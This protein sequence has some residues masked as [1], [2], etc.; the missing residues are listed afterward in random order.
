[1]SPMKHAVLLLAFCLSGVCACGGSGRDE[2]S[3]DVGV[4]DE[5]VEDADLDVGEE[6]GDEPQDLTLVPTDELSPQGVP[7]QTGLRPVVWPY[8]PPAVMPNPWCADGMEVLVREE[9][10]LAEP[11]PEQTHMREIWR[12]SADVCPENG[13]VQPL[14]EP[15]N[16][17][18]VGGLLGYER[19]GQFKEEV[20][21]LSPSFSPHQLL[22]EL[23]VVARLDVE[24]GQRLG[25]QRPPLDINNAH[26]YDVQVAGDKYFIA[27]SDQYSESAVMVGPEEGSF[28]RVRDEDIIDS[29]R[30]PSILTDDG[31]MVRSYNDRFFEAWDVGSK[32]RAWSL[33][34]EDLGFPS[35]KEGQTTVQLSPLKRVGRDT[36]VFNVFFRVEPQVEGGEPKFDM[37]FFKLTKCQ[38]VELLGRYSE[39]G[40]DFWFNANVWNGYFLIDVCER[41][42]ELGGA[43]ECHLEFRRSFE[44]QPDFVLPIIGPD[45]DGSTRLFF[46]EEGIYQ[47]LYRYDVDD[48]GQR[49]TRFSVFKLSSDFSMSV[50]ELEP[51]SGHVSSVEHTEFLAAD[52]VLLSYVR[53]SEEGY[54]VEDER[55]GVVMS[56]ETGELVDS[57]TIERPQEQ[58]PWFDGR[59][60]T[61][62]VSRGGIWSFPWYGE[63]VGVQ[64]PYKPI[65][66]SV[67][68]W[69]RGYVPPVSETPTP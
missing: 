65:P 40:V 13:E 51:V 24:T 27:V 9:R 47:I 12:V 25:C 48:E 39:M 49:V 14:Y 10:P 6:V 38:G 66:S 31:F 22:N 28:G 64:L 68:H 26:Y 15:E 58:L 2:E 32:Q 5:H 59:G 16:S 54:G 62:V 43:R 11:E 21:V 46:T 55:I 57:I 3:V 4:E 29:W 36:F 45:F 41:S 35:H 18:E 34:V 63:V 44:A 60:G 42:E 50:Q 53:R 8:T 56:L 33:S 1:M 7:T 30:N 37:M 52:T 69:N 17:P 20:V 67:S 19:D 23:G 61:D